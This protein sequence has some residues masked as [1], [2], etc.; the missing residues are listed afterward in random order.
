MAAS[1]SPGGNSLHIHCDL[2]AGKLFRENLAPNLLFPGFPASPLQLRWRI[3]P[4]AVENRAEMAAIRG[5]KGN[6][7]RTEMAKANCKTLSASF[8]CQSALLVLACADGVI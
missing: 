7:C 5:L 6:R 2:I 1:H 4:R 8:E 3:G